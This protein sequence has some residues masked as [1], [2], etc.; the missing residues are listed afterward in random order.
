MILN[1]K[2]ILSEKYRSI[3]T[4]LETYD[5]MHIYIKSNDKNYIIHGIEGMLNF[6]ND[7]SG[8]R[9]KQNKILN[10]V[11]ELFKNEKKKSRTFNH[12]EDKTGKSKVYRTSI[13]I[14]PEGKYYELDIACYDWSEKMGHIDHLRISIVTDSVNDMF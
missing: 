4:E 6:E 10:D 13:K 14:S 11:S 5:G 1:T 9:I 3:K 2:N 7:I 8:C 12:S